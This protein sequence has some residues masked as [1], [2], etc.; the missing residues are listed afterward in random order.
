MTYQKIAELISSDRIKKTFS[1]FLI[2]FIILVNAI[3]LT[4]MGQKAAGIGRMAITK[5]IHDNFSKRPI[6]LIFCSWSNPY[7]PWHSILIS[8]INHRQ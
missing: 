4:A 7:N 5:H 3:G 6:N 8:G 1:Y 2:L